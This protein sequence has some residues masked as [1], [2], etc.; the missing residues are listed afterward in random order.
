MSGSCIIK[1]Q[2]RSLICRI[3]LNVR[4]HESEY[5]I[6]VER[7][8]P[9]RMRTDGQ[10]PGARVRRNS[11]HKMQ[12][13][14]YFA[15]MEALR[16]LGGSLSDGPDCITSLSFGPYDN[17]YVLAGMLSGKL[18]IFDPISLERVN[19]FDI[20]TKGKM[21]GE[22]KV[23]EPITSISMEPTELVFLTSPMG[24]VAAV[25]IIKK[26]MHYVYI[27]LGNR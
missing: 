10:H 23:S 6:D 8:Q 20:F 19:D 5:Y 2:E 11:G 12:S 1:G 17:G 15:E 16:V 25:S 27:E 7:H 21:K 24:S 4:Y 18:L 13:L 14:K 3:N 9:A 26:E 22:L